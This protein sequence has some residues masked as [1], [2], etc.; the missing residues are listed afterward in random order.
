MNDAKPKINSDWVLA[1]LLWIGTWLLMI[2]IPHS[3]AFFP[4]QVGSLW[5]L[6]YLMVSPY[7]KLGSRADL[8]IVYHSFYIG[9]IFFCSH[10]ASSFLRGV[11]IGV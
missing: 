9:L 3:L 10:P 6:G 5:G 4:E 8:F 2:P 7:T 1:I 11:E